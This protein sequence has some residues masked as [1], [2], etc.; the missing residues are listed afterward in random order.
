MR[1]GTAFRLIIA[2]AIT[3]LVAAVLVALL[4]ATDTLLSIWERLDAVAPG[5]VAV[6][7][8]VIVA[9]ALVMGWFVLR[10]LL[11]RPKPRPKTPVDRSEMEQRLLQSETRGID[12]K[13]SRRELEE[14]A[15]R[16][17]EPVLYV[18]MFGEVSAGKTA[19]INAL[20]PDAHQVSDPRGGTT[21]QV[22]YFDWA[23]ADGVPVRL[24]DAPGFGLAGG[25]ADEALI[26]EEAV[27][28]HVVVYVADGDLTRSQHEE[29]RH[30]AEFG[31]PIVLAINKADR[32]TGQ[33]LEQIR[34]RLADTLPP[35]AVV[36]TVA[37]SAGHLEEVVVVAPD[38]RERLEQ[39]RR[40]PEVA[41]LVREIGLAAGADRESVTSAQERSVLRL[42]H[43]KLEDAETRHR[44]RAAEQL[45][46]R[47]S[48]RAVIGALAALTPGS[49]LVIQGALATKLLHD[50]ARLYETPIKDIDVDRFLSLAGGRV[51][52][53]TAI[54]LAV[55]GNALKAFPG[56]GTVAG[57]LVHAVAY[58]MIFDSLGRAAAES[59]AAGRSLKPEDLAERFE[60]RLTDE[61]RRRA[62][63]FARIAVKQL[64]QRDDND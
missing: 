15:R 16:Q 12:V 58:G 45:V 31:K 32:Y 29:L 19:L 18:A 13:A 46:E 62:T 54:V 25:A 5:A 20:M 21:T 3:L 41:P 30:L 63:D 60:S 44:Q 26:R 1:S 35:A 36:E 52:R 64:R 27:R 43:L 37:V 51:R 42:A 24:V 34:D 6:Y 33:E 4:V 50:L 9:V 7:L 38:G 8:G 48:R 14:L 59:L 57:G 40:E 53:A 2:V 39:R 55:A 28:A 17:Q 61:A 47:Y 10:L 23:P 49:D 22:R 56:L 11:A